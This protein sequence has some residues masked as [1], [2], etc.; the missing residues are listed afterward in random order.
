MVMCSKTSAK[1]DLIKVPT[2]V[3]LGCFSLLLGNFWVYTSLNLGSEYTIIN[4]AL[5]RASALSCTHDFGGL[6]G[7]GANGSLGASS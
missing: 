3:G 5:D 4:R 2:K 7:N 1:G 6:L